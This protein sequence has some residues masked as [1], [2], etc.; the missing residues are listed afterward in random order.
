MESIKICIVGLGYVGLPLAI[1]FA[2]KYEVIGYDIDSSRINQLNN[3]IFDRTEEVSSKE[4]EQYFDSGSIFTS[5]RED[6]NFCTVYIIT[7]PTPIDQHKKPNLQYLKD[8][9]ELVG[10]AINIS[11]DSLPAPPYVIYE[12]TTYPTCTEEFCVP[13]LEEFSGFKYNRNFFVGYSPERINPGDKKN[14]VYNITKVTS[15]STPI[16]R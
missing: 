16:E 6:I 14:R 4:L 1:E 9:S 2:K 13:I 10:N 11:K 5:D 8:A 3:E 7:V 15:G 12:S